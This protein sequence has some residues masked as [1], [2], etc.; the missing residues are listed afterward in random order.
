MLVRSE[1]YWQLWISIQIWLWERRHNKRMRTACMN[2]KAVEPH[3]YLLETSDGSQRGIKETGYMFISLLDKDACR[4][5]ELP[6]GHARPWMR[7]ELSCITNVFNINL[8]Y[9]WREK[10][11]DERWDVLAS[12][13]WW[14]LVSVKRGSGTVTDKEQRNRNNSAGQI[15]CLWKTSI[16]LPTDTRQNIFSLCL[17]VTDTVPHVLC[18]AYSDSICLCFVLLVACDELLTALSL[19]LLVLIPLVNTYSDWIS[20]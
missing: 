15:F 18:F 16:A 14:R 9:S 20:P 7:T 6:A 10:E 2:I 12:C 4:R 1:G 19:Q 3:V 8:K 11:E 5:L 13:R 17:E